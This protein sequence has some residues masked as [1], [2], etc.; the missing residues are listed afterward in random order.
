MTR[1][2]IM[3]RDAG[4]PCRNV[5]NLPA[6]AAL[7]LA[8]VLL[9]TTGPATSGTWLEEQTVEHGG[10]TRYYRV[11]VPDDTIPGMP[12]VF[13]LHGGGGDYVSLTSNG[14]D[15][16]WIEVADENCVLLIVPNGYNPNTGSADGDNQSW[17]DC[18]G[19]RSTRISREDDV[20]F[21]NTLI[22]WAIATY[23]IDRQRV[24][25]TGP[26][27]GGLMS[28]RLAF[29]LGDRIAAV[30]P[31]IANLPA[32][33]SCAVPVDIVPAMIVNGD[34]E[35]YYMPW[36]GGCV[37]SEDC[38]GGTVL[39]AEETRDWWLAHNRID[40]PEPDVTEFPDTF[41][42]DRST[43]TSWQHEGGLQGSGLAFYRVRGG[44]HSKPTIEHP[45]KQLVLTLLGLGWQNRDVESA[46]ESWSFLSRH[47]L[48]GAP[49]AS[50]YPGGSAYIRV[51][52]S[53]P[54]EIF[55][56]WTSD[57]GA[58]ESYG[59]Y[60]GDLESGYESIE[61]TPN[62]CDVG[63]LETEVLPRPGASEFF[64]IVPNDGYGEGDYG[65][66]TSGKRLPAAISCYPQG[67]IDSC[68]APL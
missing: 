12:V 63:A 6:F 51:E 37:A 36:D 40:D 44:G 21:I 30:A 58:A 54:G 2:G 41:P 43:V 67:E 23:D 46:R 60:R 27:N 55:L 39:S 57:C 22:N 25:A 61:A 50:P 31:F 48:D 14:P 45:F 7:V 62:L 8:G 20:G 15:V 38:S 24:Y 34:A 32:V 16:E 19:D 10:L 35:E 26:S 28:Y 49:P 56:R 53:A 1:T 59:V 66:N 29:E 4:R 52:R 13:L 68:A 9:G 18:R 42:A 47:T 64:L 5:G 3:N 65:S 17:N 33:S 11:Y